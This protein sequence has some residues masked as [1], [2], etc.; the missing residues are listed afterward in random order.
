MLIG[1]MCWLY[2]AVNA[3]TRRIPARGIQSTLL[4]IHRTYNIDAPSLHQAIGRELPLVS[5]ARVVRSTPMS[6]DVDVRPSM[7]RADDGMGLFVRV[8]V[9]S[10]AS[11]RGVCT[12]G[13]QPKSRLAVESSSQRA[14]GAFERDLRMGLKRDER[15]VAIDAAASA[16][17]ATP[18]AAAAPAPKVGP[19]VAS[20]P[21]PL[22]RSVPIRRWW[23]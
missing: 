5:G 14:L 13:G 15:V 7:G 23:T 20:G 11:G 19:V 10:D 1:G 21:L 16:Q 2:G 6:F 8:D 4:A 18:A 12:V 17:V 9:Q 3:R 22:D